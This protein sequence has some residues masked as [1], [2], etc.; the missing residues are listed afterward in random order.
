MNIDPKEKTQK[1]LGKIFKEAREKLK[2][3][4]AEVGTQAGIDINYYAMIER[5][6][7]N[8]TLDKIRRLYKVLNLEL[9]FK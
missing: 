9:P 6:K 2:L 7:A 8:I 1:E 3:T 4:Q 5:G